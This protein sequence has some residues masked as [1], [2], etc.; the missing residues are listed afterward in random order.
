MKSTKLILTLLLTS[1]SFAAH[2][3]KSAILKSFETSAKVAGDTI[4]DIAKAISSGQRFALRNDINLLFM[5]EREAVNPSLGP[6]LGGNTIRFLRFRLEK[7]NA[8]LEKEINTALSRAIE[9]DIARGVKY[10][11]ETA[12]D[13]AKI[14]ILGDGQVSISEKVSAATAETALRSI[15]RILNDPDNLLRSSSAL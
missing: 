1:C 10:Y 15:K 7:P 14:F 4:V 11:Q 12:Q 2:A 3:G 6:K 8:A 13:G 9:Q 5:V